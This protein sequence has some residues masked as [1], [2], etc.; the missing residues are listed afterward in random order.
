MTKILLA[1]SY[2]ILLDN[3]TNLAFQLFFNF[4]KIFHF[5]QLCYVLKKMTLIKDNYKQAPYGRFRKQNKENT[6]INKHVLEKNKP[7]K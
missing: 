6:S 7:V 1:N 3:T 5:L 4:L 2:Q